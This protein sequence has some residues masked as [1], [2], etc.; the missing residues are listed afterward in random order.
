MNVSKP[1]ANKGPTAR[2]TAAK[3][4]KAGGLKARLAGM[5]A[6]WNKRKEESKK[7][8]FGEDFPGPDGKYLFKLIK[9]EPRETSAGVFFDFQVEC[10]AGEYQGH[11]KDWGKNMEDEAQ[12]AWLLRDLR[13]LGVDIDAME[14]PEL[15]G[16]VGKELVAA[17]THLIGTIKQ[18]GAYQNCNI[19]RLVDAAEL[20]DV[21]AEYGG[22]TEAA[23]GG[24]ADAGGGEAGGDAA[25]EPTKPKGWKPEKGGRVVVNFDGTWYGGVCDSIAP[26]GKNVH[27]T[28]DDG[29]HK[30]IPTEAVFPEPEGAAEGGGDAGGGGEAPPAVSDKVW[31]SDGTNE[32]TGEVKSVKGTTLM[33]KLDEG[34]K[35]KPVDTSKIEV[36]V[37]A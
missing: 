16:E 6:N 10:A 26:N 12:F 28:F 31:W 32:F 3:A 11:C 19:V 4:G 17:E 8:G 14:D 22:A 33:V 20:E 30:P 1:A 34:G 25:A 18:S 27:I 23:A 35:M 36:S 24:D 13:K 7:G 15:L 9:A 2:G 21:T 5:K 37:L 29:D